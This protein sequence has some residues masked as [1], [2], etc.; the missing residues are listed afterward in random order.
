MTAVV[1][2]GVGDVEGEI[3][4]AFLGS[5]LQQMLVLLFGEVLLEVHVE[6]GTT[7]EMLDVRSAMELE[8]VEDG[9]RVVFDHVE[10]AV[11]AVAGHEIAVLTIPLSVLHTDILG[12][13]HLA[14][15]HHILRAILLIILL[16][17]S[18][19]ALYEVQVVV[20]RRDLQTHELGS[21][22]KTVDTN[23]E[24]LTADVDIA[25]VEQRQHAMCLQLLQVLVVGQLYLVA[26][27]DDASQVVEI[28]QLV[29]HGK[30]DTTVQVDGEH[31]LRTCAADTRTL[32]QKK[33]LLTLKQD[34]PDA[35][36]VGHCE[37][38][39]VHKVCPSFPVSELRV[40]MKQLG[41]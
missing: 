1:A 29:V 3:V 31:A 25:C 30:L 4:A 15:E 37:L 13:D 9:Q 22:H 39:G 6:G 5:H 10:I 8:L 20:V 16:D 32:A 41:Y 26:E 27:V 14:V 33:A 34:Y 40:Q 2:D 24:V 38:E 23:G 18:E 36:I 21:L 12:R 35:E 7:R 19:D 28:V 17:E 11:V